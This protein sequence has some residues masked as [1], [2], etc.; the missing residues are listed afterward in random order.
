MTRLATLSPIDPSIVRPLNPV[1]EMQPGQRQIV[2]V[3]VESV[4]G[5][6]DLLTK[7]WDV[8]DEDSL[9]AAFK[10]LAER[11]HPLA[12]GD[13]VRVREQIERLARKLLSYHRKDAHSVNNV[14]TTLTKGLGTHDYLISRSEA[15]ELLGDQVAHDDDE[16]EGLIWQL[17]GDFATEML[18]GK[19]FDAGWELHAAK[20]AAQADLA[21]AMAQLSEAQQVAHD[22]QD[23]A[24]QA[25]QVAEVAREQARQ[26]AQ[27]TEAAKNTSAEYVKQKGLALAAAEQR[28]AEC[29][30]IA[31]IAGVQAEADRQAAAHAQ[32]VSQSLATKMQ[33]LS[34][35]VVLPLA[36][37]ESQFGSHSC[38]REVEVSEQQI[39]MQIP[40]AGITTNKAIRQ[41]VVRAGWVF[42]P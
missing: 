5:F 21:Q 3:S 14:V 31:Q 11:V 29:D 17:Y 1:V 28:A 42:A 41:E 30:K 15:R 36:I 32:A 33:T 19:T 34:A 8:Q 37:V 12:L 22:A 40:G 10:I 16:S 25:T 35:R 20:A 9:A 4:A 26:L 24:T 39:P 18:L 23:R 13:V 38:Q 7:V 27:E 2:S 6:R